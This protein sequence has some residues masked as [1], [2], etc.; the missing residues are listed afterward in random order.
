MR[1][2]NARSSNCFAIHNHLIAVSDRNRA[3]IRALQVDFP[4][5]RNP[6]RFVG[7]AKFTGEIRIR[8]QSLGAPVNSA[9]AGSV[10]GP[11]SVQTAN[12]KDWVSP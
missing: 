4:N 8:I 6:N 11:S 5:Q 3:A 12:F 1:F 10:R 7:F 9:S 2:A